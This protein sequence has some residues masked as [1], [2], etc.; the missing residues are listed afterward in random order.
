MVVD[1][2]RARRRR[3]K[4]KRMRKG[5]DPLMRW[6]VAETMIAMMTMMMMMRKMKR[7]MLKMMPLSRIGLQLSWLT[8]ISQAKEVEI[9]WQMLQQQ[10]QQQ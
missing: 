4:R 1:G 3:R 8:V 7:R 2:R 5:R 6:V 10:Q 9:S